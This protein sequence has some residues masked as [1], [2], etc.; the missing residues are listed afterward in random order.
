MAEKTKD[1][2]V[3]D[4]EMRR[5]LQPKEK[6]KP[7]QEPSIYDQVVDAYNRLKK[8]GSK[9]YDEIVTEIEK[10][11][12]TPQFGRQKTTSEEKENAKA[13]R[14][15]ADKPK[16]SPNYIKNKVSGGAIVRSVNKKRKN[17]PKNRY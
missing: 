4:P 2:E 15:S 11:K 8:A 14:P 12:E 9:K 13:A 16:K 7:K 10:G 3:E 6:K 1:F 5:I 17:N